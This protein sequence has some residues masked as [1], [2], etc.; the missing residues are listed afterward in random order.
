MKKLARRAHRLSDL[1]GDDHDLAVLLDRARA[2][3]ELLDDSELAALSTLV[4]RRQDRLRREALAL[5]ARLY[6]RKPRK[7]ASVVAA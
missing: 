2:Q 4:Q 5:G 6:R 3:P 1:L 7:L